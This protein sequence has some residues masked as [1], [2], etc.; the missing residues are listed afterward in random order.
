VGAASACGPSRPH[1]IVRAVVD[2]ALCICMY[3]HVQCP[4]V[5]G[6][7]SRRRLDREPHGD[8]MP[9]RYRLL[10][11]ARMSV[12]MRCQP[13]PRR[14]SSLPYRRQVHDDVEHAPAPKQGHRGLS[15]TPAPTTTTTVPHMRQF[16]RAI[17]WASWCAAVPAAPVCGRDA[18]TSC[19]LPSTSGWTRAALADPSP[20]APSA[21]SCHAW[22]SQ[23]RG[24]PRTHHA[25]GVAA[26]R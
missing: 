19:H 10:C 25:N 4:P 5:R 8:N 13:P 9:P 16:R 23:A 18:G 22:P 15:H 2:G 11:V 1:G 26:E 7:R 12:S 3:G 6:S 14:R 24:A 17:G 20:T 21:S